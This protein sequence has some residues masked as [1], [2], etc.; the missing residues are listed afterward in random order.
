MDRF[1]VRQNEFLTAETCY[2]IMSSL[3]EKQARHASRAA[4]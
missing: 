4:L 1:I 2:G 3:I